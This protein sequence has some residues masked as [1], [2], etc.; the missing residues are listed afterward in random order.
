MRKVLLYSFAL[1]SVLLTY[2]CKKCFTCKNECTQCTIQVFNPSDSSYQSFSHVLCRDSFTSKIAY[3]AAISADTAFGYTCAL[4]E[5]TVVNEVCT[6][7]PGREP[8]ET[9]YDNGG[10]LT[11]EDK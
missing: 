7:N 6:N 10:R 3:D 1:L 5:P 8:Y 9:Y 2:S 4:T 11:C